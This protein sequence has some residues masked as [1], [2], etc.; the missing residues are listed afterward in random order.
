MNRLAPGLLADA[1]GRLTRTALIVA[2]MHRSG[3]SALA[4]TMSLLGADLPQTL[5]R[6]G[7]D[8]PKGF[9][10]SAVFADANDKVLQDLNS[11]WDDTLGLL[12]RRREMSAHPGAIHRIRSAIASEF[13]GEGSTVVVK[14]PRIAL[15]LD[16]WLHAFA[17]E[18]F[19]TRVVVPVRNP[20][21]V[22]A[23]L[24]ARNGFAVGR[25]LL[26]WLT[27]FLSAERAS[28]SS[29]RVFVSYPDLLQDWRSVLGR[30]ESSLGV[31]FSGWNP[32]AELEVDGFLSSD[33]RHQVASIEQL[34]VRGDVVA[35]VKRAYQWSLEAATPGATPDCAVLDEI[36]LE[37]EAS[38]RVFAPVIADQQA[39][40]RAEKK[41]TGQLRS[42]EIGRAHV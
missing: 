25:S 31:A 26:L 29:R 36:A 18:G 8:N 23:S 32:T 27:Y 24:A 11:S 19:S 13:S 6:P 14:E 2:G 1:G 39:D 9:W 33:D 28:R 37:F 3:T 30:V 5:M 38:L 42:D 40:L 4:R 41:T 15:L 12:V 16:L 17:A 7:A 20:L 10:E 21:E 22:S 34:N 35:W